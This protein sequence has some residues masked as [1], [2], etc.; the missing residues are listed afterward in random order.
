MAPRAN[1]NP[2][3]L[4]TGATGEKAGRDA[5]KLLFAATWLL[6]LRRHFLSETFYLGRIVSS[7]P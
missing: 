3:G 4:K 1:R 2:A 5:P 6:Q 7:A